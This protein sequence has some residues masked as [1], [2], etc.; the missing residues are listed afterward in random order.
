MKKFYYLLLTLAV[1][2][3][4]YGQDMVI[5]GVFDGP[6][7]GGTPKLIEVY[8]INDIADLST[9]GIG[10]A[11]NGGGSDGQ[12][13]TFAGSATAGD[14]IYI[15]SGY[16]AELMTYFDIEAD[17]VNSVAGVNGDDALELFSEGV[18]ID[19]FG[20]INT[21]GSGTPWDYLDGWAYR[22][23]STG[24]DGATFT[25]SNW[26]FSGANAVDGCSSNSSCSSVFPIGTFTNGTVSDP[27]TCDHTFVMIDSYGDGWNGA[28]VDILINGEVLVEGA[29]AVS[30][31]VSTG[32]TENLIFQA[33]TGDNITLS[34]W[35]SGS[36]NSE[37]SW[38][39]LDNEGTELASG[40]YSDAGSAVG[41]CVPPPTCNHTFVMNDSYGDGWNGASVDI[42]VDGEVLV[43]GAAAVSAGVS[44]G[45]TENLLFEATEGSTITLSNWQSGSYNSEISWA[46]LD[47]NGTELDSGL[48]DEL[49][50]VTANCTP[51]SCA[52]LSD[53]VVS[54]ITTTGASIG[55]TSSNDGDSFEYQV[56]E[57]GIDPTE[58]GTTTSDNPL[59][60]TGLA[61]GTSFDFYVRS[62]C[63][64]GS[65]SE[66]VSVSFA[67]QPACGDT[68]TYCYDNGVSQIFD[69]SVDNDGDYITVSIVEG[70]TEL[71][72]D[73]LV[74]YDSSD[75]SGTEL[76]RANGDHAGVSITST[77]GVISV[78]VEADSSVSCLSPSSWSGL[79]DT[80]LVMDIT[81]APP[82]TCIEPSD[83]TVSDITPT[84]ASVS[85]TANNTE[86]AWEYQVV[87]SG[88]TPAETGDATS[89]NPLALIG[90]TA[91]TTYDV[92]VRANCGDDGTSEWVSVTFTTE[93]A[94]IVP[95]YT[96]DFSTYPGEFWTE[97]E[98]TIAAGPSGT[99]SL[100][101]T[102][103]FA[104]GSDAPAA[105]INIYFTNRDEWLISPSFD[106]S[107]VNYYLNVDVAATEYLSSFSS[108][109]PVD[110][111]WGV[112]DFVTLMVSE[113]GGSTW[114][115]LYRWDA[116]NN[117]GVA[118]AAMPEIDLSAYTG[119]AKFAFYAES[120]E[121]N[122]DIDFFVDNFS[123]TSTSLG[124]EDVDTSSNF[125]YF[126]NPVNDVLTI[127][128][129]K[130]V[131]DITVFNML[132][133]VVKRQAPNTMNCTVDLST[134]QSG[135]YFVQVSIDNTV[136]TVRVLKK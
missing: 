26:I 108:A 55:W 72:Y 98:G 21:D 96:N 117:P 129:Q 78:W 36:Y 29:A 104:H 9:Y 63:A 100:W 111:I 28:S 43:E 106:L 19:T 92:Y 126:P 103:N 97:A 87:E 133:Q 84:T 7:S 70:D 49:S 11:N 69:A 71:S 77:T 13:L 3:M 113:D 41:Y 52:N 102:G 132:G 120:T 16:E 93:P 2:S 30:A 73:D 114:T 124:L 22:T 34:N 118:G 121:S 20:D 51:P 136:Q 38:A 79:P 10:S 59:T 24:P 35:Q 85:W 53:L 76:Y 12:E 60:L 33:A 48:Y 50:E 81:C 5:T 74:I 90:L 27:S 68:V 99:T 128:A 83:L 6:L 107:G 127:K 75:D 62:L 45:S 44:T 17:Y 116:N 101:G 61:S 95:N 14:F 80:S 94:P 123:I 58:T 39:I 25:D 109:D 47:G 18:V 37:I 105:Y 56:V 82:P 130:A 31:G 40:S 110:A 4:S 125:T 119:L 112:D 1:C 54:A 15:T 86:T 88:V 122:E 134:M 32:S 115:E 57:S 67:T 91:N 131:E 135:A 66:W 89:D 8:V 23:D 42:L 64:D 65:I 46:I